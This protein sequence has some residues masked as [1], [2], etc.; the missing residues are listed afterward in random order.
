[1]EDARDCIVKM[2][3]SCGSSTPVN[4]SAGVP[5]TEGDDDDWGASANAAPDEATENGWRDSGIAMDTDAPPS[6]AA[7][8]W[9]D[10]DAEEETVVVKGGDHGCVDLVREHGQLVQRMRWESSEFPGVGSGGETTP[11]TVPQTASWST[12]T[13]PTAPRKVS[14]GKKQSKNRADDWS[15]G[16]W[17]DDEIM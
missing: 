15:S 14:K 12:P 3:F 9:D 6:T 5:V 8:G 11:P 13:A 17:G 7:A 2:D 4:V 10:V 16:G 1:M